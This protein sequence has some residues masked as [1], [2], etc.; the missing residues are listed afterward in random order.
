MLICSLRAMAQDKVEVS[1]VITDELDEPMIG[2]NIVVKDEPGLGTITDIEGKYKIKV[3]QYKTLIFSYIGYEKQEVLVKNQ[4][5]INIKLSPSSGSVLEEV[6]VTGTGAQK[7]ATVTGAISTVNLSELKRSGGAAATSITN[8]LAGNVAGV[9]AMQTSGEPGKNTSEFWVRGISTFGASSG[10]LV[11]VDGFERSLN[12]INVEDI[13]SFSVLK[14]ASATAIYGSKGANGVVLITTKRG[15]SGKININAK[16]EGSYNTRTRT[17][18]FVDGLTY[19]GMLNEACVTRNLEPEYTSGELELLTNGLDPDLYPNVNWKDLLLKD[20]AFTQRATLDLNGGGSTARYFLS[21]S[22]ID[23]EGMYKTDSTLKKDYNTNAN[24]KRWNYRMNVDIDITKTTL[25][26]VGVSGSL[27]KQNKPGLSDDI[28]KSIVGTTPTSIPVLYSD[29]KVPAFGKGVYTNPWVLATQS[30]YREN[31]KNKI[32]TNVTLEQKLDFLVKGL[33]FVGRFGYDTNNENENKRIKWPE[34]WK[35]ERRRDE[36]GNLIMNRITEEQLMQQSSESSGNRLEN[37]EAE[38]HYDRTF[39]QN[40]HVGGTF[41]YTQREETTTVNIGEDIMKGISKRNQGIAGRITYNWN[42]RYFADFNFGYNGSE[43]FAKDHRFGFFPAASVGWNI[44]EEK[45]IKKHLPWIEMLK[46]RYSYGEVGNDNISDKVR[47][48]Y[49]SSFGDAGGYDF[50]D[51]N[52]SW[53]FDGYHYTQVASNNLAW[54][55]AKKHN[56]GV[57]LSLF[58]GKFTLTVDVYQDTREKIFMQRKFLSEMI[59]LWYNKIDDDPRGNAPW[60]NVGKMRSQGIDGNFMLKHKVGEVDF[61]LRGN[62]TFTK[63]EVL[64]Y[65]EEQQYYTYKM[66]KGYRWKQARGLIALGLFK[67]Y[68][69]I[70]NSPKQTFGTYMPGDIKYKDVN[71]DGVINEY[72]EVPIGATTVPNMIYGVGLSAQWKG[73]DFNVHFQGAGKSSYM[74]S[75]PAVYAFSEGNWG[76]VLTDI[77]KPGNRWISSEIS[78][79]PAT[80]DIHAK[81]PRLSYGKNENNQRASTYWL[82]DGAYLRFKTLEI[83]YTLPKQLV[84]RLHIGDVRL[85]LLGNNLAVWDSLKLWDPEIGSDNGMAYPLSKS[86]TLGLTVNF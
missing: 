10:A 35:A 26:R 15:K 30:G 29:G 14:D 75:G 11:L 5:V 74:I 21:G 83:G 38:L 40:H 18:E 66:T 86:Y 41:K 13:E 1:G 31:W 49:L 73:F 84:N 8:A 16:L 34:Q 67:D 23:E 32:Q 81:Y 64:E 3:S 12:E 36:N 9:I 48:P 50:G 62:M 46:I 45:F 22:Y 78:G 19:A 53:K 43:N 79:D 6:V 70:R 2:V 72:D 71:A 63:N 4:K 24:M 68:D 33:S 80:E 59:G 52:S 65:D 44:A 27:E 77:A 58:S 54:E 39:K 57:D 69:D 7:K 20:G 37:F 76:N 85:Y 55:V 42:Y 56:L 61:T 47:F 25:L 82:R 28:W 60:A 51:Y 17:P